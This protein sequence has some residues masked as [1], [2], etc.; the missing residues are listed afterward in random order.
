MFWF[1]AVLQAVGFW[2]EIY[3]SGRFGSFLAAMAGMAFILPIA[4][5]ATISAPVLQGQVAEADLVLRFGLGLTVVAVTVHLAGIVFDNGRHFQESLWAAA[6][7]SSIAA[8]L[9]AFRGIKPFPAA[10]G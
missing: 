9:I 6:V 1:G 3:L 5:K 4:M 7:I 10:Q 8:G 2:L